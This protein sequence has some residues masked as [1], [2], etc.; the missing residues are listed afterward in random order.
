VRPS[1]FPIILNS[2]ALL[3]YI[4]AS[5]AYFLAGKPVFGW[6]WAALS[7][8]WAATIPLLVSTYRSQRRTAEIYARMGRQS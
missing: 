6:V 2:L 7:L 8:I 1:K 4:A 3:F 5:V